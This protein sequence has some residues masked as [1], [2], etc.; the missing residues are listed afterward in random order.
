MK[1]I[2]FTICLF[3]GLLLAQTFKVEAL[4]GDIKAQTGTNE[5]WVNVHKGEAFQSNTT[6]LTG[7]KSSVR[8]VW[9]NNNF[10]LKELS[11]VSL[12]DIKKMSLDDLILAL[13]MEDMINAP[14][15]K[16]QVNSKNTAVYGTEINGVGIPIVKSNNFGIEK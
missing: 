3:S 10:T 16:E 12:F 11:A 6:I 5:N 2:I 7:E 4:K 13:A 1:K 14:H 15:K 8:L 9:N